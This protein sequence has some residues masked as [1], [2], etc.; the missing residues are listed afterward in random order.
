MSK[1][2]DFSAEEFE[3]KNQQR[4]EA[5]VVDAIVARYGCHTTGMRQRLAARSRRNGPDDWPTFYDFCDEFN[6]YLPLYLFARRW[7]RI[8]S[9]LSITTL[10]ENFEKT[11]PFKEFLSLVDEVP[12]T[13]THHG[14]VFFWPRLKRGKTK[15]GG[16][17]VLHNSADVA[18]GRL[19]LVICHKTSERICWLEPFH[20][21]L[22]RWADDG[23][24]AD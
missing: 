2:F 19:G 8:D 13:H 5:A 12:E 10:I 9:E 22:D 6:Y 18:T 1:F 24:F 11:R 14:L 3:A 17:L 4:F 23:V 7:P 15:Q 16:A 21:L 20:H